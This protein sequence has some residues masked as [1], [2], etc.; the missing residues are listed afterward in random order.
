MKSNVK[1]YNNSNLD[2]KVV[3][4][5]GSTIPIKIYHNSL[6]YQTG[7]FVSMTFSVNDSSMWRL[8]PPPIAPSQLWFESPAIRFDWDEVVENDFA[9]WTVEAE[10]LKGYKFSYWLLN[11][12]VVKD[13]VMYILREDST[14]QAVFIPADMTIV[15]YN[16]AMW[17]WKDSLWYN[18]NAYTISSWEYRSF[19]QYKQNIYLLLLKDYSSGEDIELYYQYDSS[20][21][22]KYLMLNWQQATLPT[23]I[24]DWD[25]VQVGASQLPWMYLVDDSWFWHWINESTWNEVSFIPA[26]N[27]SASSFNINIYSYDNTS[28]YVVINVDN[29]WE[30]MR[31]KYECKSS[32]AAD[33]VEIVW[34]YKYDKSSKTPIAG[35]GYISIPVWWQLIWDMLPIWTKLVQVS[36]WATMKQNALTVPCISAQYERDVM[37]DTISYMFEDYRAHLYC[38]FL[39]KRND[40]QNFMA[41][42]FDNDWRL[43][44]SKCY[45]YSGNPYWITYNGRFLNS[46]NDAFRAWYSIS[47]YDIIRDNIPM[48]SNTQLVDMI[49]E[50]LHL[51]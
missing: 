23:D 11:W 6:D 19:T 21:Q 7:N 42:A 27:S 30:S 26:Y 49:M 41:A 1:I 43:I 35:N 20:I 12:E 33:T 47:Y 10:P 15:F 34:L 9:A 36:N 5:G 2:T 31:I 28:H 29:W 45:W 22:I 3:G 17:Q 37:P 18:I 16:D 25:M 38:W 24:S 44:N 51:S 14:I 32:S 48:Y 13:N 8:S 40:N 46:L 50:E 4:Y 39:W